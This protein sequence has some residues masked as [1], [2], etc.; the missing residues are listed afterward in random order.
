MENSI[1]GDFIFFENSPNFGVGFVTIFSLDFEAKTS[2]NF[3]TIFGSILCPL[4]DPFSL[5]I[6]APFWILGWPRS[7][8]GGCHFSGLADLAQD[9]ASEV[10]K[11]F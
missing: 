4:F 9:V 6:L 5:L 2:A 3:E 1:F 7:G 10:P 8:F 11:V